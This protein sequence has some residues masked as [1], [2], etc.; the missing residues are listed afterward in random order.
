M[1]EAHRWTNGRV[2]TGRRYV[3]AL[4]AEAGRITAAGAEE[5]VARAAPTGTEVHDLAGHLLLPGLIDAHLHIADLT[6][7][8][9]GLDLQGLPSIPALRERLREWAV[10]HPVGAI[11]G[12]GWHVEQFVEGRAPNRDD[13]DKASAERPVI[14]VHASGHSVAVNSRTLVLAGLAP[15]AEDPPGGRVGRNSDGTP[16]GLLYEEA[17]RPVTALASASAPPEAAALA[18]TLWFAASWGLTTVA[19][20]STS[21]EELAAL[22]SLAETGGLPVRVRAYVRLA[23]LESFAPTD[24]ASA[25]PDGFF[26]VPGAK[27]FADGAFG[28]R[29]AWLSEP[30]ADAPEEF[31]VPV[32]TEEGLSA[33]IATAVGRGLAPAVHA[34]GDRAV[35]RA[36]RLVEP[37]VGATRAPVRIE[38]AA[39]TPPGCLPTL[40]R[41]RPTLVVQPGFVWSDA[42]L[43]QRLGPARARWAYAF[44][45]LADRGHR[46]AGSSDAPYDPIDPWRALAACVVR[47]DPQGRSANPNPAEAIP[48]EEATL[49]YTANAGR[50]LGEPDLGLLEAGARADLV[51]TRTIDLSLALA[52]GASVVEETWVAGR[53]LRP[54]TIPTESNGQ[55][56]G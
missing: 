13:L 32:G 7:Y 14:L 47:S 21:P 18:R 35:E 1:A 4:L 39:L 55:T 20:M 23:H 56:L 34:I 10:A 19:T 30:Y 11:V 16:N 8:R 48:A 17:M 33:A 42:W 5:E 51:R 31:G 43:P 54:G 46:L 22:R 24:L 36:A 29:T 12:R 26:G 25:G 27:A 15:S 3:R 49:L 28:P 52:R 40:D 9:E 45:T 50:A 38:H 41:V 2:F 6:H 53:L 44:R 37:W